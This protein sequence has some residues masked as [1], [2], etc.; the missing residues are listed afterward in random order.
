MAIKL[1]QSLKQSQSLMMTPQLQQAIKLLTLTHLEMTN[2]ISEEMVEN[3]MLEEFDIESSEKKSEEDY[4]V[5][6]LEMHSKEADSE[7]FNEKPVVEKDDF[8]WQSYIETYN[9]SSSSPPSM[10]TRDL[11]ELP[12]YEN[13]IS[14]NETL[15]EH[16]DWQIRMESLSEEES[17][18]ANMII[19]NINDDGYLATS[20]EEIIA[21]SGV[22]RDVAFD[23]LEVIQR[24]DPVGCGCE[25][26][27][28]CLLAQ[29][30]IAEERSPLLEKII[31]DHLQDLQNRD[32][33]KIAKAL[34][35]SE[36]QIRETALLLQNFHP[37]PGRLVAG[38]ETH[39][40]VPDI[41]VVE[42]GGEFVVQ[43]NDDGVPR[44]RISQL[45]QSMLKK[46]ADKK[47]DEA[48]EYVQEKLR[49]AMWLIKSIQ[50]R[51]RTIMKVS[52]AI[53]RQQQEF[54]K[55]GPRFLKPMV[56]RDVANEIGMHESTVS[57]VTTNKYMHTPIGL[58]EL[59]YFFNSGVGGK[60]GGVDI[61]SEVLK[62][63]I[64]NLVENENTARPL[65]DQK[66]AELL[67]REDVAVARRTIAKYREILGILSSSK[68]KV[69]K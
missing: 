64:K 39:Y 29:A 52:K 5:E 18:V 16:L 27:S 38:A 35:V 37:K 50:N 62:L 1:S 32:P 42:A 7:N 55:K 8:D 61:S 45:Y 24:L 11:D 47:N 68:R 31:R 53:L 51:Q 26:L 19:H 66:I 6:K 54:F 15:A 40:V 20:F 69:K 30:R 22:E 4:K 44:L 12:N 49:S 65:S 21:E 2:V 63:K 41:Y 10:A 34:G 33:G 23:V 48:S 36:E 67:S 59:K 13:I 56:L 17:K 46:G 3:P 60:N 57:R 58:F 28:D 25:N 14:K 9:N 43:L